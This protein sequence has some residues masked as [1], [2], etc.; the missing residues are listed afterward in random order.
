MKTDHPPEITLRSGR[1]TLTAKGAEAVAAAKPSVR[2][3]LY[4]RAFCMVATTLTVLGMSVHLDLYSPKA[5]TSFIERTTAYI[6]PAF[7]ASR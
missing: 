1:T 2:L 7:S 3:L 6:A 4:A 5:W